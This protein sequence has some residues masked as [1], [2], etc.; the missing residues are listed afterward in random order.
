MFASLK[1]F[2]ADWLNES[3]ATQRVLDGLTDDSLRQRVAPELR[4]LGSLAWHLVNTLHE[5]LERAGITFDTP[6]KEDE[7]VPASAAQ[8]AEA[9]R[10]T[11]QA[12]LDTLK[13]RWTDET[14]GETVDMYGESWPNG[15][16]LSVLI[17]HQIHHRG[18]ITVLMRQAGLRVP[19]IYGPS[20]EE[21]LEMGMQPH[22]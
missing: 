7:P 3:A 2:E 6:G 9:Y 1:A 20:R 8:I 21:W 5:M 11:S 10:L 4:T 19:G 14:L 17:N 15:L 16:T 13:S 22:A 12:L 18:Q